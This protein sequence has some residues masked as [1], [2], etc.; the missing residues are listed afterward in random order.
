MQSLHRKGLYEVGRSCR[1]CFLRAG[2]WP[3]FG[4][5]LVGLRGL[6]S[7]TQIC[8]VPMDLIHQPLF[9]GR[10]LVDRRQLSCFLAGMERMQ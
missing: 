5:E 3:S 2:N 6:L 9:H 8:R 1:R 7:S 10:H 4:P